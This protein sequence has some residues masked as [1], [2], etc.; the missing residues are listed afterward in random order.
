MKM[1]SEMINRMMN[2]MAKIGTLVF[3]GFAAVGLT[4]LTLNASIHKVNSYSEHDFYEMSLQDSIAAME[5]DD[6]EILSEYMDEELLGSIS[7]TTT[8]NILNAY[9]SIDP[10]FEEVLMYYAQ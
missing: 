3:T 8:Q 2:R 4:S 5:E 7:E 6:L 10:S 1:R 9:C